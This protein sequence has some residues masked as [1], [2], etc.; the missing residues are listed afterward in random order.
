MKLRSQ[1]TLFLKQMEALDHGL[2]AIVGEL[3]LLYFEM[4]E[5]GNEAI[6]N[7]LHYELERRMDDCIKNAI[8][9][10]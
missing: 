1:A 4:L 8:K 2:V 10:K 6:D 5:E 9:G 7:A 3:Q